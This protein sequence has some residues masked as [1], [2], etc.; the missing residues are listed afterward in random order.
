M[1]SEDQDV[2]E[3]EE[4]E[5]ETGGVG[6]FAVTFSAAPGGSAARIDPA[7]PATSV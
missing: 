6:R 3:E 7:M 4:E 2:E 1:R 5:A